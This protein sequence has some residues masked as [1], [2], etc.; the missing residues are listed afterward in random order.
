MELAAILCREQVTTPGIMP[1]RTEGAS[2]NAGEF[3]SDKNPHAT[4][5]I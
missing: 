1:K 4:T 3:A 2:D 5:S